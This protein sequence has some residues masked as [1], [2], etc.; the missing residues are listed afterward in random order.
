M[1]ITTKPANGRPIFEAAQEIE[2][3][4]GEAT[5]AVR[6]AIILAYACDL[7][8]QPP[9]KSDV[10]RVTSALAALAQ[11][12]GAL[13]ADAQSLPSAASNLNG[14]HSS[15]GSSGLPRPRLP[16]VMPQGEALQPEEDAWLSRA[17][18]ISHGRGE[19]INSGKSVLLIRVLLA[20]RRPLSKD[21][22]RQRVWG[23]AC[24]VDDKT[25]G[26]H[27]SHARKVLRFLPGMP[28]D[29]FERKKFGGD[30]TWKLCA[31]ARAIIEGTKQIQRCLWS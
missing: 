2:H 15:A 10:E 13:L 5:Q 16:A 4:L 31:E 23:D 20:A 19:A 11:L 9:N 21:D 7:A 12:V 3:A 17:L 26:T 29:P 1:N 27:L 14:R 8:Q 22:L 28:D 6:W 18:E 30:F 24:T 25:I